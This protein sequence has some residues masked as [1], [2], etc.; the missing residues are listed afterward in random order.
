MWHSLVQHAALRSA[1]AGNL[2]PLLPWQGYLAALSASA[3]SYVSMLQ[4]FGPLMNR[5]GAAVS[6]TYLASERIVPGAPG[7]RTHSYPLPPANLDIARRALRG[8]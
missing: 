3:Y 4:R 7:D 6:L 2:I 8:V 5:G 1:K